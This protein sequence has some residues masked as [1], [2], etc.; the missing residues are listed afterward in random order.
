MSDDTGSDSGSSSYSDEQLDYFSKVK[1]LPFFTAEAAANRLA[2]YSSN[3]GDS[4]LPREVHEGGQELSTMS[5][6]YHAVSAA[7]VGSVLDILSNHPFSVSAGLHRPFFEAVPAVHWND[8][9]PQAFQ[10]LG[11]AELTTAQGVVLAGVTAR[12]PH[13]AVLRLALLKPV[14]VFPQLDHFTPV[15]REMAADILG[16]AVHGGGV[17]NTAAAGGAFGGAV[18]TP[19]AAASG[20]SIP[21]GRCDVAGS[22][23]GSDVVTLLSGRRVASGVKFYLYPME[24]DHIV[25]SLEKGGPGETTRKARELQ[26]LVRVAG[27]RLKKLVGDVTNP[28]LSVDSV[29]R[30]L[31]EMSFALTLAATA[32]GGRSAEALEWDTWRRKGE[33]AMMRIMTKPDVFWLGITGWW[34]TYCPGAISLG[35]FE[36]TPSGE[37]LARFVTEDSDQGRVHRLVLQLQGLEL[38]LVVMFGRAFEGV[39]FD[40]VQML[41]EGEGVLVDVDGT[42]L[43]F[44]FNSQVAAYF[45][46]LA[47]HK[48]PALTPLLPMD[49]QVQCAFVLK[50]YLRII[51]LSLARQTRFLRREHALI[52]YTSAAPKKQH[53]E[54]LR[55]AVGPGSVPSVAPSKRQSRT[56]KGRG[57]K[58]VAPKVRFA[59]DEVDK[60]A[61]VRL[62]SAQEQ[63]VQFK[64]K[65]GGKKRVQ[66]PAS[67]RASSDDESVASVSTPQQGAVTAPQTDITKGFAGV[68]L[69]FLA[70]LCGVKDRKGSGPVKCYASREGACPHGSHAPLSAS[71]RVRVAD[72][73]DGALASGTP[74][75]ALGPG[76]TKQVVRRLREAPA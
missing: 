68:C 17:P 74:R 57:V 46:S 43:W 8:V 55:S 37:G 22:K 70:G 5:L 51:D 13:A 19:S 26:M 61:R 39:V 76:I 56:R 27:G 12:C 45:T 47:K 42:F 60:K 34:T 67:S 30:V 21:Q 36:A 6:V 16:S 75:L 25:V 62:P 24:S 4:R 48:V 3:P 11:S 72:A 18:A 14:G 64:P 66:A 15:L 54:S 65:Q 53:E 7:G 49:D 31:K 71:D 33:I 63:T 40:A 9:L 58:G 41:R 1:D 44:A 38:W 28:E 50:E 52:D 10:D 29:T 73:L 20:I 69:F 35:D 32:V 23:S 59:V 2:F